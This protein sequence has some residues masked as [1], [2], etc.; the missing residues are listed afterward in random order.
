MVFIPIEKNSI[1]VH[2]PVLHTSPCSRVRIRWDELI[3]CRIG[4]FNMCIYITKVFKSVSN[5]H[6]TY[7]TL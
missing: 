5:L 1:H 7:I 4:I 2:T 6:T 3:L